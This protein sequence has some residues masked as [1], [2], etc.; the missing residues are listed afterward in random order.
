VGQAIQDKKI[1]VF[2]GSQYR[3]FVHVRDV[4]KAFV[5]S[6]KSHETGIY[7]LG[8]TN[9]RILD[10]AKIVERKTGCQLTIHDELRD[11]RNYMV[12]SDLAARTLNVRY[13]MSI[14]DAVD[15]IKEKF[16]SGLIK[17][18]RSSAYSN[19]EYLR[20]T[21]RSLSIPPPPPTS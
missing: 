4:A 3:P 1:S 14:D 21:A 12:D 20:T 8:G 19:E 16:A 6:L 18:Y 7:N 2:G 5:N 10:I 11:P 13:T 9:Y 17:D 15:E